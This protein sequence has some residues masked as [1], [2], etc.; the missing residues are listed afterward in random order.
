MTADIPKQEVLIDELPTTSVI[1][2][3]SRAHIARDIKG[4]KLQPGL[5]EVTIYG[6][7]PA[8]DEHSVQIDGHGAAT[9]TDMSVELVPNRERFADR[10]SDEDS[11]SDPEDPDER[12]Y[13]NGALLMVC[14]ELKQLR[15]DLEAAMEKQTSA[16]DQ[17]RILNTFMGSIN[18]K[19]NDPESASK[20]IASYGAD[21]A[22]IYAQWSDAT[23]KIEGLKKT[24][25][26]KEVK[27][28]R[29]GKEER[30]A[31]KKEKEEKEKRRSLQRRE[32]RRMREEKAK[33]WP[34]K[35]YSV[36]LTLE[37]STDTHTSS[38]RASST[39]T[40]SYPQLDEKAAWGGDGEKSAWS[41]EEEKT[42]HLSLSYVVREVSWSPRYNISISSQKKTASITYSA[43]FNNKTSE[44]WRD[45]KVT[46][47]T[48][49]TSYSGLDDAVPELR[50]WPIFLRD[51]STYDDDDD[52]VVNRWS[53]KLSPQ[54]NH[55][56]HNFNLFRPGQ[57]RF[58]R[59]ELFGPESTGGL[60][61]PGVSSGGLFGQ[62]PVAS[63]P[64]G[65]PTFRVAGFGSQAQPAAGSALF[66]TSSQ[67]FG[68][69]NT[70][71][72][73]PLFG[74]IAQLDIDDSSDS[75]NQQT[76]QPAQTGGLFGNM[77]T[78]TQQPQAGSLFGNATTSTQPSQSSGLFGGAS[79]PLTGALFGSTGAHVPA[80]AAASAPP[81]P[82]TLHNEPTTWEDTG[83]TTSYDLPGARTIPPS[84]LSRRHKITT[85]A[86]ADVSLSHI[87]VPKLRKGAFLR[88]ELRN[89]PS[90]D[91]TLLKGAAG[92]TLDGTFLGNM[93]LPRTAPGEDVELDLGV[94]PGL[95]VTY[96]P[97]E[98][99]SKGGQGGLLLGAR[100]GVVAYRRC[101]GIRNTRGARVKVV[102]VDQVPV[103]EEER[104]R[105]AVTE[106]QGLVKGGGKVSAGMAGEEKG[107][108]VRGGQWGHATAVMAEGGR[109]EWTVEVEAG[110]SC[111][112]PLEWEVRMPADKR[113]AFA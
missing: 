63:Q 33:Y 26:K 36:K 7:T 80:A 21:R 75:E 92:L 1:I 89:P 65:A 9:I 39:S 29:D 53:T 56:G 34:R 24:I 22:R 59:Y 64:P 108:G 67:R 110:K 109:V 100:E 90:A 46:L 83:L 78:T 27:L 55:S 48:S 18:A 31:K 16:Q 25:R 19:H 102:V 40:T 96:A 58:N 17:L 43:E 104:L 74:R 30:K 38:R 42:V 57:E 87:A 88:A 32:A 28:Q 79:R 15:Q 112:L 66:N 95:H 70:D 5:N 85:I 69:N 50:P 23:K 41:R 47:S 82:T 45:A 62:K 51:K 52:S 81:P 11:E 86:V 101:V 8:A 111:R 98:T 37:P 105:V 99:L 12:E 72:A 6:I 3:P 97:P 73:Q 20:A 10:F 35:V 106:P 84:S 94:D 61:G 77:N 44:T 4:I 2:Y 71:A 93:T 68:N 54:E 13:R 76:P 91:I 113:I 49:Q 60:F 107:E 14:D 103:S